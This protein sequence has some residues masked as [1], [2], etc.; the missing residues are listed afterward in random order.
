MANEVAVIE[1]GHA[2]VMSLEQVERVA[3]A[4]AR[5]AAFGV[6]DPHTALILC[7]LAQDE[8]RSA[9]AAARDYHVIN[10]TP[11]KKAD[12]MLRDFLA[13]G[14]RVEWHHLT[15]EVADATFSHPAGGSVRIVWDEQ[16]VEQ[17]QLKNP[18]HTKF[19]RQMKRSRCVSEGV[20]TV[21]PGATSGLYV[22]EEVADFADAPAAPPAPQPKRAADLKPSPRSTTPETWAEE[23][24]DRI[25]DAQTAEE[26]DAWEAGA[27]KAMAKLCKA[28]PELH[29]EVSAALAARRETLAAGAAE[30]AGE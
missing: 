20:R 29:G 4:M 3:N 30:G 2:Q 5:S 23:Q 14:G 8:G 22:P 10:G 6:K 1:R 15:D 28:H 13:S 25:A 12:A 17:A 27:A 19:P 18:M 16:R 26:L 21:Y 11:T 9:V 24:L 7:L